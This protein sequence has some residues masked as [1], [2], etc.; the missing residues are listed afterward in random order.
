[1]TS[2]TLYKQWV[3]QL[4]LHHTAIKP[5]KYDI[6]ITSQS[7]NLVPVLDA[8]FGD[9]VFE[10]GLETVIKLVSVPCQLGKFITMVT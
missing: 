5:D 3:M 1:M 2:H 9:K 7:K 6:M 8:I 4:Q 10:N